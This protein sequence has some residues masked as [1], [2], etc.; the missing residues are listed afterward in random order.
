MG[1]LVVTRESAKFLYVPPHK[2]TSQTTTPSLLDRI[3]DHDDTTAWETFCDV[4]SP[5]LYDYCRKRGLQSSDAADVVQEVL[6]RVAKGI[7]KFEYDPQRGRFRDWLYRIVFREICRMAERKNTNVL[8]GSD[9]EFAVKVDRVW[10]EHFHSH[11]LRT[12]L[13]RIRPRFEVNTWEAFT[14][15]WLRNESPITVARK[16]DRPLE[17]VYLS[18][19]R[20]LKRL[21][22][23][24]EQLADE[25]GM[26]HGKLS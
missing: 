1:W 15:V 11:I 18:K 17:F 19:S 2:P 16:L 21:R 8:N 13:D 10:N 3:R 7:L 25:A 20:V 26:G 12:A 9:Q 23:E 14:M 6:L 4:Y 24:V 5:L 22:L